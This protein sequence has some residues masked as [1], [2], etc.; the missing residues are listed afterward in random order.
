M[1]WDAAKPDGGLSIN[2][3]DDAIR[4]NNAWL[5]AALAHFLTFPGSTTTRGYPK[6]AYGNSAAQAAIASPTSGYPFLRTDTVPPRLEVSNGTDWTTVKIDPTSLLAIVNT[7]TKPQRAQWVELTSA[8]SLSIDMSASDFYT[9]T[10]GHNVT[11]IGFTNGPGT[12]AASGVLR[13]KQDPT[14]SRTVTGW[15]SAVK[16]PYGVAPVMSTA[17]N[18]VDLISWVN[19]SNGNILCSVIYDVK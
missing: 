3:G 18:A 15:S 19:D 10:L 13:I 17:P 1:A 9:V 16:F 4:D 11:S 5:E 12:L 6:L 2:I 7:W 8:T 14:G